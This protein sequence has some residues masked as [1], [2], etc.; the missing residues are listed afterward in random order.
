VAPPTPPTSAKSF[1]QLKESHK[2]E[3]KILEQDFEGQKKRLLLQIEALNEKVSELEVRETQKS[4]E[5]VE[6]MRGVEEALA[7]SEEAKGKMGE[8]LRSVEIAK[9]KAMKE[10][11]ERFLRGIFFLG[12]DKYF[13]L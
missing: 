1:E 13:G 2:R 6:K 8:Q 12:G 5:Q 11:E 3:V 4:M 7:A 10:M 9:N